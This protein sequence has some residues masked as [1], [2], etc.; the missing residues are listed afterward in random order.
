MFVLIKH[1]L[2]SILSSGGALGK[3]KFEC[4]GFG[5]PYVMGEN[6]NLSKALEVRFLKVVLAGLMVA[7]MAWAEPD[8][9][10]IAKEIQ[11]VVSSCAVKSEL[12][13]PLITWGGD[14]VTI[15]ANGSARSTKTDSL[16]GQ[17]QLKLSLKREDVFSKQLESYLRCDTPFLRGTLGMVHAASEVTEQDPRTRMR[18]V[19]QLTWS[20]G[21]DALVVRDTIGSP[22]DLKGKKIAV[23]AYGPHLDYLSKVLADAG[24]GIEDVE[25]VWT[26]DLTGTENSP[27]AVFARPDVSAAMVI[28]PDALALTS[29]GEVGTGAESSVRGARILMSTKSA[30]RVIADVYAVRADFYD[31]NPQVVHGIVRGLL[32]AEEKVKELF[33]SKGEGYRELLRVAGGLLL[34]S[35]EAVADTESLYHDAEFAGLGGN[36]EFFESERYP[37]SFDIVSAEIQTALES[38]GLISSQPKLG[39]LNISFKDLIKGA[40]QRVERSEKFDRDAVAKVVSQKREQGTLEQSGLFTFQVYFKP[41]QTSFPEEEYREAFDKAVSLAATY[42][43]AIITIEGHSDPLKYLRQKK[44]EQPNVV[45]RKIRQSAKNLS[46]SRAVEVRESLMNYAKKKG[47]SMDVSQ[48]AVVGHGIEKPSNGM[49]GADPCAPETEDEWKENMRVEFRLIQVEAEESVFKPV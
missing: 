10:P 32:Q 40:V 11:T 23:Q 26:K 30:N 20:A 7:A 38:L 29:G 36:L 8:L 46:L 48:F 18:V 35:E 41:N 2:S 37:R 22:K 33:R 25:I 9:R 27:A 12:T 3:M 15:Y 13:L 16:F 49:C 43:G 44:Q 14:I 1:A 17:Q 4:T 5:C 19:Y 47:V 31:H 6:M 45:L 21:G 39:R 42:G 28:I 24:V 34:D